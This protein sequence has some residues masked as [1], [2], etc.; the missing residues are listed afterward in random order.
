[1]TTPPPLLAPPVA[2]QSGTRRLLQSTNTTA[3]RPTCFAPNGSLAVV[4]TNCST[5]DWRTK[6]G[7][8][9]V[10]GP[11]LNQGYCAGDWAFAA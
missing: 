1:M 8:F 2:V 3:P 10:V 4:P 9:T 7:N 6:G 5:V 11:I